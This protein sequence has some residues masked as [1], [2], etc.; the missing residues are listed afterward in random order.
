MGPTPAQLRLYQALGSLPYGATV[1][2][3]IP[4]AKDLDLDTAAEWLAAFSETLQR[5]S[6]M[7]QRNEDDLRSIRRDL[8]GMGR[9]LRLAT[10][11]EGSP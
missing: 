1:L 6:A 10:S 3:K 4:D 11:A 5:Y 7:A 8:G 9:L 2:P